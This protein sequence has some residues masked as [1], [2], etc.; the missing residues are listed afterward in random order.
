[1]SL[2]KRIEFL[3]R[4]F[5][6]IP[7]LE[8]L[9]V[10]VPTL[11]ALESAIPKLEA[12]DRFLPRIQ[13][14]EAIFTKIETLNVLVERLETMNEPVLIHTNGKSHPQ[15]TPDQTVHDYRRLKL[16]MKF[17][18]LQGKARE[19]ELEWQTIQQ[20]AHDRSFYNQVYLGKA[21]SEVAHKDGF[22]RGVQWCIE[23]FG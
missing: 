13:A 3:W 7:R 21:E 8:T 17:S 20:A 5:K 23:R 1:M 14:L 19:I 2:W 15:S 6:L 18:H 12:I 11:E 9:E 4:V 22:V 10:T 16:L